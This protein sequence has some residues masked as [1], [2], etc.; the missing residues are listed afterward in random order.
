MLKVTVRYRI[1]H[2]VGEAMHD[3]L[4]DLAKGTYLGCLGS[5]GFKLEIPKE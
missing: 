3:H 2:M 4:S 5:S 1:I